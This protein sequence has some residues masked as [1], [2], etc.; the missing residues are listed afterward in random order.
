MAVKSKTDSLSLFRTYYQ[1]LKSA[2]DLKPVYFFYGD[3]IF[4][5][6]MLQ[7]LIEKL[8][9]DGVRDFNLD[10]L[11]GGEVTAAKVLNIAASYPMMS[12]RRIVIVRD[13]M[14]LNQTGEGEGVAEFIP[15]LEN[16]NPSTLLC[17]IDSKHPDKRS[18]LGK[19]ISSG[20]T[21]GQFGVAGFEKVEQNQLPDWI[22]KW[23]RHSHKRK[24]EEDAAWLLAELTGPDLKLLS[25]EIEKLCTF[26]D[27]GSAIK[28]E[29]VKKVTESYREYDIIKLKNAVVAR[30][31]DRSLKIAEQMLQK[32]DN[33]TGEIFKTVGF[34]YFLFSNIW[35]ICKLREMG[36]DKSQM[37][38][39]LGISN[40]ALNL[41]YN[42]ASR[43][44]LNEMPVIFEALLDADRSLK[45]FS[46][47]T[48]PDI[49]LLLIKRITG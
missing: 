10:L 12:D 35:K 13:F 7:D 1:E 43:F 8:I 42:E 19:L 48:P 27:S 36:L 14:K 39:Q 32:S 28:K 46:T 11:Y 5:A 34:F 47:M 4:L 37:R 24:I 6:D 33:S 41:N 44:K 31:L 9:P 30:D 16:P 20:G 25:T 23:T 26:V 15:Y 38:Q 3:E 40:F 17:L 22:L 49:L 29:H 21:S 45:G 2:T 18:Q